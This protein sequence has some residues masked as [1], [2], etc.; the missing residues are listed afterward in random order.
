MR[1]I[2]TLAQRQQMIDHALQGAPNEV[3]GLIGGWDGAAHQIITLP[4]I[5]PTPRVRYLIDP[6][7]FLNAY[8]QIERTG[9][10]LIGIYHSHPAGAPIPSAADIAEAT[11]PDVAYVIIGFPNASQTPQIAAWSIRRDVVMPIGIDFNPS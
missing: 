3:C 10:E 6:Q 1:L 8:Y 9:D 5:A 4:N 7:A 2:V 11:W